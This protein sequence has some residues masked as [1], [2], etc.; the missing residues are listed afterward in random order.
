MKKLLILFSL[1]ASLGLHALT[2]KQKS[3]AFMKDWVVIA[4]GKMEFIRQIQLLAGLAYL[5]Q[6]KAVYG[7]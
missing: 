5:L 4:N 3:I 6:P 2:E 7:Q 1:L